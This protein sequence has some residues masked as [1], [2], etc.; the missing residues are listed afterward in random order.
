MRIYT[1]VRGPEALYVKYKDQGFV[2]AGFPANKFRR[3]GARHKSGDR[4]LL[5]VEVQRDVSDVFENLGEGADKAPLD[6]FL[7]DKSANP[8]TAGE[9]QWNSTVLV[10]R[11]PRAMRNLSSEELRL[12]PQICCGSLS[13]RHPLVPEPARHQTMSL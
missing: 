9:T 5:Q 6:Q 13:N 12:L 4:G 2:I 1:A 10:D 8:K 11:S 3:S 7:T